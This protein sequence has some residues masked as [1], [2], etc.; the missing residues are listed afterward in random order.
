LNVLAWG[1]LPSK[2][3]TCFDIGAA[4]QLIQSERN[5]QT[6]HS[7]TW[8]LPGQILP[9][10]F[11]REAFLMEST[12]KARA[13]IILTLFLNGILFSQTEA[14]SNSPDLKLTTK[15]IEQKYCDSDYSDMAMWRVSLQLTYTNTGR[16]PLILYKGSNLIYY[17]LVG[18]NE[19]NLRNK[20][21]EAKIHV[22]W[23]TSGTKLNEGA[24]PGKQFAVLNPNE[25][26]QTKGDVSI[27]I[28]L[29]GTTEFIKSGEHVLQVVTETWPA[30][31]AQF[32]KL[33]RRWNH[34]GFLWGGNITSEPT[35]FSLERK[36]NLVKC[37]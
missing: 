4:Q 5:E 35:P 3:V 14:V 6:F 21:Y 24:R 8:M 33:S 18:S 9:A 36:P 10:Q 17:V 23:I 25:S 16:R 13:T 12:M 15:I 27:P 2:K 32:D 26:Y 31:E 20:Q 7:T 30:D 22:G 1:I 29:N 34:T 19:R 11:G 28:D 37:K